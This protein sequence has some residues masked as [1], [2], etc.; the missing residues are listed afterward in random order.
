MQNIHA[1][2]RI[3]RTK[4]FEHMCGT[5]TCGVSF[6]MSIFC[7]FCCFRSVPSPLTFQQNSVL[8]KTLWIELH[9]FSCNKLPKTFALNMILSVWKTSE[10]IPTVYFRQARSVYAHCFLFL[11]LTFKCL[12]VF[13]LTLSLF[14]DAPKLSL[15]MG[16]LQT[17]LWRMM[18][19]YSRPPC[20]I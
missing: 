12:I 16:A 13:R 10:T 5:L 2:Q 1:V 9:T 3:I 15:V 14:H 4:V 20:R 8:L 6:V 19:I 7:I 18:A 11:I 17:L